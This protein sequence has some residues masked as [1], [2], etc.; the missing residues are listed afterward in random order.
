MR[1]IGSLW[2]DDFREFIGSAKE[3]LVLAAPFI[4][5][6]PLRIVQESLSV[7]RLGRLDILTNFAPISLISRSCD[8]GALAKFAIDVPPTRVFHLPGL[9]AKVYV[10]D[11]NRAIVTSANLTANAFYSNAEVGL[12][13][14]ERHV[15]ADLAAHL[16]GLA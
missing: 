12:L 14:T 8:P 3:S 16:A 9:H 13:V 4:T 6:A 7:S 2:A 15:V 5:A 1:V 10:A 11:G